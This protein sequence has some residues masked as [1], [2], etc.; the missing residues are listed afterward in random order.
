[1]ILRKWMLTITLFLKILIPI[2]ELSM[3]IFLK[4]LVVHFKKKKMPLEFLVVSSTPVFVL[5][6]QLQI[7]TRLQLVVFLIQMV[8]KL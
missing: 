1:M 8:P 6:S 2:L 3:K 4:F 5:L 7:K